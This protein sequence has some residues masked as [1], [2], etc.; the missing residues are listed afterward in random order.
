MVKN[1]QGVPIRKC[2]ASCQH[3][4]INMEGV[5]LCGK[6]ELKVSPLFCCGLWEMRFEIKKLR[7]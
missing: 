2:C 6:M 7:L 1:P 5:R 4:L 3:R